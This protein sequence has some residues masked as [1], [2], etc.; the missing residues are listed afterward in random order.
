[1]KSLFLIYQKWKLN[2]SYNYVKK[3][4]VLF[5]NQIT[6]YKYFMIDLSLEL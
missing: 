1:M 6:D 3:T 5:S 4:I 2:K